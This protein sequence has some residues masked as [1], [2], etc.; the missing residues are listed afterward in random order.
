MMAILTPEQRAKV[1]GKA[2]IMH[3]KAVMADS[4]WLF[5]SSANFTV[6]AFTRN[7]ELGVLFS[8]G[9]APIRAEE[10]FNRLVESAVLR[11]IE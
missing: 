7:M 10:H 11:P 4:R 3:V 5:L 2:G 8:G 9:D 6:Q 1:E